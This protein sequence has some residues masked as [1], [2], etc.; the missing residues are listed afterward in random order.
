[1]EPCGNLVVADTNGVAVTRCR[2]ASNVD[3]Y[4]WSPD[5]RWLVAS[6]ADDYSNTDVWLLAADAKARTATSR[7]TSVGTPSVLVA[8]T[9]SWSRSWA[10][11]RMTRL[12][13]FTSG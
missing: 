12:T 6:L 5:S 4:A 13:S 11:G 3:A 1:V 9:A 10:S 2:Q 7:A 8:G